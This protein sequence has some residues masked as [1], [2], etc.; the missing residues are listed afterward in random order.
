MKK[1][2]QTSASSAT[3][4]GSMISLPNR[5]PGRPYGC[6]SGDPPQPISAGNQQSLP[7]KIGRNPKRKFHLPTCNH[8]SFQEQPVGFR[9]CKSS[10]RFLMEM[11][12]KGI[13]LAAC[14]RENYN[15]M[16][17]WFLVGS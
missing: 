8:P 11:K 14:S 13:V 15:Q 3:N 10:A 4:V 5:T 6:G 7:L 17:N 9:E 1:K 2:R 16:A 12:K